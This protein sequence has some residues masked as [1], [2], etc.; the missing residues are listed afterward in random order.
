M[1]FV[2]GVIDR[3][4]RLPRLERPEDGIDS[5]IDRDGSNI[6]FGQKQLL[7]LARALAADDLGAEAEAP[8]SPY[9]PGV[10]F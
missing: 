2:L 9:L 7:S 5:A 1:R 6:S 3:L 4:I 10:F 8:N